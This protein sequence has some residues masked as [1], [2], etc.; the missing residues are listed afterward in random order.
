MT[1]EGNTKTIQWAYNAK[2]VKLGG[3]NTP[4]AT[5]IWNRKNKND[6]SDWSDILEWGKEGWEMVN[7]IPLT[8]VR[9][10]TTKILFVFKRP[11]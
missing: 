6:V 10:F 4:D 8:D 9:G 11:L 2:E 7:S 1:D 5:A 3:V